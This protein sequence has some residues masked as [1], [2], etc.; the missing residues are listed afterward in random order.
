MR[1]NIALFTVITSANAMELGMAGEL[2]LPCRAG[3]GRNYTA[4]WP[5][6]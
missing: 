2:L 5:A 3:H 1:I 4:G 6:D